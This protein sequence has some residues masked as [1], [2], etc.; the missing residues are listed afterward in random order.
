MLTEKSEK[1]RAKENIIK[2]FSECME[3]I[4]AGKNFRL[5]FPPSH[6]TQL[7]VAK[8]EREGN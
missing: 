8:K 3:K 7:G 4:G 1:E 5:F 2:S 6:I